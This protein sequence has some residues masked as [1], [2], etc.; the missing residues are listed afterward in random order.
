MTDQLISLET[1][2]LLKEKGFGGEGYTT[3]YSW[4][5]SSKTK[6]YF[7]CRIPENNKSVFNG[8]KCFDENGKEGYSATTQTYLQKWLRE[9]HHI[10]VSA[11]PAYGGW[12][13]VTKTYHNLCWIRYD[14][15]ESALEEGLLNALKLLP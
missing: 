4:Q 14:S 8:S 12:T 2:K 11:A 1:A 10:Y 9:V 5:Y 15:Y 6:E 7:L 13:Y 3:N